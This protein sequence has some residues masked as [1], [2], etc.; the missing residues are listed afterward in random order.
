MQTTEVQLEC[1]SN[2]NDAFFVVD[3]ECPAPDGGR[4]IVLPHAHISK[5]NIGAF[6]L[7]F[8]LLT[9]SLFSVASLFSEIK[10]GRV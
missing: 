9:L 10:R 1:L 8:S 5:R 7:F 3:G 2:R 4:D 6:V